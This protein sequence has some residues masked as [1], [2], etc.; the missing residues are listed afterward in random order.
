[1]YNAET[2]SDLVITSTIKTYPKNNPY[3]AIK[4]KILGVKY[5]LSL[6]FVGEKK[7]S[8]LNLVHRKKSYV[9]NVLSFPLTENAG[10][11]FICPHVAKKEAKDFNLSTNGYVAYLFIHGLL[12]L[13]G[14]DH[15]DT[16]DK[17]EQK[18]LKEFKIT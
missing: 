8:S 15:S 4:R 6:V 5:D 18:Y 16:M 2:M 9:P 1:M 14:L 13:K 10:E 17:L 12:H 7:A 11:I 3:E